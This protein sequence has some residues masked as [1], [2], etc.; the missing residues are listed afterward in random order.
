M[1]NKYIALIQETI[2]YMEDH[3]ED[4]LTVIGVAKRSGVS[5]WQFQRVFKAMVGESIGLY[6]RHR[7]LSVAAMKLEESSMRIIDI[8]MDAQ[9]NS[10]EAF[11]RAF[12]KYFFKTP[13]EVR[14]KK[15]SLTIQKR[16]VIT[17]DLLAH[18][19]GGIEMGPSIVT[20]PSLKLVGME[21][22]ISDVFSQY[23]DFNESILPFWNR[24]SARMSEI[25]HLKTT[26]GIGLLKNCDESVLL[27]QHTY[28]AARE[29]EKFEN[30]PSSM[31][32]YEIPKRTYAVFTNRGLGDKTTYTINYIYG[33][34][35][36]QSKYN[37]GVGDDFEIFGSRY[38]RGEED[39]ESEYY[40]PIE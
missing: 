11:S 12:K 27:D 37:R 30:I 16:P 33:S 9:F 34:W 8:A 15:G 17:P 32:T 40:L 6:L 29:V 2:D 36:P 7:R 22:K 26:D 10:Q 31:V 19:N 39:S 20:I 4:E 5:A 25:Q 3:L 24:F 35:L 14:G 28:L 21:M 13:N 18:L 1:N 38:Q 23:Q